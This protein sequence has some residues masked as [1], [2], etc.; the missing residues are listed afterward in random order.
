MTSSKRTYASMP[1]LPGLLQSV[2]LTLWQATVD[3]SLCQRLLN[4]HWQAWLKSLVGSLLLSPG[5]WYAQCFVCALQESL[6]P[7]SCG[8]SVIK[9]HWP[10]KSNSLGGSQSL[11]RIPRLGNLLWGREL[12]QQCE[13]FFGVI[14]LQFVSR[15]AGGSI[16]TSSKRT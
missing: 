2:P 15:L 5:T 6:F 10:S 9:S 14:V 13:N 3:P 7:Q 8:K 1:H 11:C 16:M 4:T 12:Q